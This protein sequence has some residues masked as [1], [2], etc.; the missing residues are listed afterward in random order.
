MSIPTQ[1]ARVTAVREIAPDVRECVLNPLSTPVH[2][3]PGQWISTQLPIGERQPLVRAYSLAEPESASGEL[4]LCFD[5]VTAGLGSGYLTAVTAGQELTIAGPFGNF[6]APNPLPERL[7]L[8]ARFTGVVPLRCLLRHI[9]RDEPASAAAPEILFVFGADRTEHLVYHDEF[10][11]LALRTPRFRYVATVPGG[12][13]GLDGRP[14]VEIL[15]EALVAEGWGE[16]RF[17]PMVSGLKAFV[18]PVR[19]FFMEE[20]GFERRDVR[21]ETYD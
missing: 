13:G 16:R 11:A 5:H 12:G 20:L 1:K 6:T 9:F 18:R 19:G 2:F 8:A 17:V 10:S 7:V 15:R 4:V 21:C 3:Q 14:E